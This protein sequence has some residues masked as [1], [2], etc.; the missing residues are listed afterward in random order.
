MIPSRTLFVLTLALSIS[1]S[2]LAQPTL[3]IN[4]VTAANNSAVPHATKLTP[5]TIELTGTPGAPFALLLSGDAFDGAQSGEPVINS[6]FFLHPWVVAPVINSPI[7]PVFDGIGMEYIR[8]KLNSQG[9]ATL[10]ANDIVPDT[11]SP[12]FR[13]NANGK[14]TVQALTPAAAFLRN[15]TPVLPNFPDPLVLALE[16]SPGV[17]ISLFLQV[18][19]LNLQTFGITSGNGVKLVFDGLTYGAVIGYSEG[20]DIDQAS[21]IV[22]NRQTLGTISDGD[23]TD[24]TIFAPIT[25]PDFSGTK[26]ANIDLW[27]ITLA[28]V[29]PLAGQSISPIGENGLPTQLDPDSQ[30]GILE[31]QSL[32]SGIEVLTGTIPQLRKENVEFTTI[33]LPGDR[34]LFHWRDA[35]VGPAYGFGVYFRQT[36]EFK[37]VSPA[38]VG[39]V[40]RSAWETEVGVTPD[41]NR[42]LVVQDLTTGIDRVFMLNL[43]SG[44]AGLF[45]NGLAYHDAT[46]TVS[47]QFFNRVFE[48]SIVFATDGGTSW[49]AFVATTDQAFSNAQYPNR[50]WR[51][52]MK[53]SGSQFNP[54][55]AL[56]VLPAQSPLNPFQMDRQPIVSE[57]HKKVVISVSADLNGTDENVYMFSQITS[58]SQSLDDLT[59]FSA[60]TKILESNDAAD[61]DANCLVFSPNGEWIA[62]NTFSGALQV[63][64]LARTDVSTAGSITGLIK[65]VADGGLF[66]TSDFVTSREYAFAPDNSHLVFYQGTIKNSF[67][68][69]RFDLFTFNLLTGVMTNRTATLVGDTNIFGP[70]IAVN[71]TFD[72]PTLDPAG[73][74]YSPD[75]NYLY[76]LRDARGLFQVGQDRLNL[77][78]LSVGS[79]GNGAPATM[80][81]INVTGTEFPEQPGGPL[82]TIGTL[83]LIGDGSSNTEGT[84]GRYL[85]LRRIGGT[86][87]FAN[88]AYFKARIL[89]GGSI[90]QLWFF[91]L[92]NPAPALQLTNFADGSGQIPV[93]GF[94]AITSITPSPVAPKVAFVLDKDGITNTSTLQDLVL[95]D[96]AS[97]GALKR[98]P[99]N[100]PA[101]TRLITEGSIQF[102]D[103]GPEGMFYVSGSIPR[104][105]GT[106]DGVTITTEPTN[107]I[108]ATAFF[109]RLDSPSTLFPI[110]PD[111]GAFRRAAYIYGVKAQ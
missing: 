36:G 103:S 39:L 65:D 41:G 55:T 60:N 54:T 66:D 2:A 58:F 34:E 9:D 63:P 79:P 27:R 50:L 4:G 84:V 18:V 69:D 99:N 31:E 57:D 56:Q 28:G 59:Q 61:G 95:L 12:V 64:T 6:G 10:G 110:A 78:A 13:F 30:N 16:S 81:L 92:N 77:I 33:A 80:D 20:L 88:F 17:Q 70:Y 104:G 3:K 8:T 19:E 91:D 21:V 5:L 44:A 94:A 106:L 37:V 87:P 62:F 24:G 74:F 105:A 43:E 96:L 38:A 23:L 68:A 52:W 51:I 1:A 100:A 42:A 11:A 40:N 108:D 49:V 82:P 101:F 25:A 90:D 111:A 47:S 76:F 26:I 86:G 46:P 53:G 7:H 15:L 29:H 97:F 85:D 75:K 107:P 71:N 72:Q 73:A 109:H 89:G 98:V 48:E 83:N 45:E 67:Q 22:A 32:R 93:S 14:F 102:L 35:S